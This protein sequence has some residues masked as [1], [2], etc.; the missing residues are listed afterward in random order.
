MVKPSSRNTSPKHLGRKRTATTNLPVGRTRSVIDKQRASMQPRVMN[1]QHSRPMSWHP[2]MYTDFNF[3]NPNPTFYIDANEMYQQPTFYSTATVNGLYT[4]LSQPVVDEPQIQELITP[5]EGLTAEEMGQQY[6][7][8]AFNYQYWMPHEMVKQQHSAM[9]SMF[10]QPVQQ[11]SWLWT[12]S[13]N[14][15][16]PTAP[17][18]PAFLPIQGAIEASPLDLNTRNLPQKAEGEELVAMGLYDSP[19]EVQTSSLL[20]G[21]C[22]RKRS[23]KLEESFEPAPESEKDDNEDHDG[24]AEDDDQTE[25]EQTDTTSFPDYQDQQ[26]AAQMSNMAG[27]SFFFE[28]EPA[29]SSQQ[30][31][32]YTSTAGGLSG[33]LLSQGVGY[34]WF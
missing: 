33:G 3:T 15:D 31:A 21:G 28:A 10:P 23:L 20:F 22:G 1:Q 5:L 16:L 34:G 8:D 4:P 2:N 30:Q 6:D 25:N 29:V 18:S 12:T 19:A 27:Q 24:E 13:V 26:N 9:D 32:V 7:G 17:S 11:P 14:Q